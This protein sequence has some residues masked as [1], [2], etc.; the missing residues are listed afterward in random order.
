ASI[1]VIC[2]RNNNR[3]GRWRMSPSTCERVKGQEGETMKETVVEAVDWFIPSAL[4]T[5]TASLWQARIFAISHLVGPCLGV[6]I[7]AYLYMADPE[8]GVPFVTLCVLA[9]FFWALPFAMKF[10]GR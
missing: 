9:S 6:I 5:D 8:V 7:L 3:D 2:I 4:R 1:S 10:T